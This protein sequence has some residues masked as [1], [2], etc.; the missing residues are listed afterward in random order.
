MDNAI[1]SSNISAPRVRPME[2]RFEITD[3]VSRKIVDEA[4]YERQKK[5]ERLRNMRLA[6]EAKATQEITAAN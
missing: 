2:S 6:R 1:N 3:T 4:S 5:T